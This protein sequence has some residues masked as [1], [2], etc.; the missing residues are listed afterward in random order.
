MAEL[1]DKGIWT[2]ARQVCKFPSGEVAPFCT[3]T[4]NVSVPVSPQPGESGV[5]KLLDFP[6]IT[7]EKL[8]PTSLHIS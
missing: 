1:Q 6:Q 7:D 8:D 4:N 2:K 5:D 3:L